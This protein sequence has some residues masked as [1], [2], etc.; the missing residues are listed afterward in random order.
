MYIF[1][2]SL[3]YFKKKEV[4]PSYRCNLRLCLQP[5]LIENSPILFKSTALGREDCRYHLTLLAVGGSKICTQIPA[6]QMK[7]MHKTVKQPIIFQL[8]LAT[9]S[10]M[11]CF[12]VYITLKIAPTIDVRE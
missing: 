5:L 6:R 2:I 1:Q 11:L 4:F 12:L 7:T 8:I 10:L 9:G 3:I